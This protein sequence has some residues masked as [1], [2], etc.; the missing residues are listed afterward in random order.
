MKKILKENY[1]SK[2][3]LTE[4]IETSKNLNYHINNNL[5][6]S[7]SI[8][9]PYSDS[10]FSLISEVRNLY[11]ENKI[12]IPNKDKWLIES[13]LGKMV[14]LSNGEIVSLDCPYLI[15]EEEILTESKKK[16]DRCTRL[17]KQKYDV[18]PSAYASGA[19]VKCRQ[20]KIWKEEI[21]LDEATKTDYSKEK[22]QGLHGWFSRQ[23]GKGKTQGWVDCNTCRTD[24]NGKK[25]C[26]SCGR[27]E[28]E[29]RSK[30]PACRPTPSACGTKGKGEKWGK[31]TKMGVK[32]NVKISNI[33]KYYIN[34][35]ILLSENVFKIYSKNYFNLINEV[36]SLYEKNLIKLNE[37]DS[38]II[39]NNNEILSEA[40]YQG[41][42]V[43]L[44]Y[45]TRDTGGK[46]KY[47]VYVK[48]PKTGNIKKISFGDVH[49]G[50]T[51]KVSNPEA[52]KSFAARHNCKDKK[53]K[54][55][56][57]YWACN[58]PKFGH[59]WGGKTT[60]SYW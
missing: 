24:S 58:L 56:A 34:N 57:G 5:T 55:K 48:N 6:L 2:M 33:L 38:W 52:R 32:E 36:R 19:V 50:L 22:E 43:K 9:R 30:Y 39:E 13:D 60:N 1:D 35:N 47:K 41:K 21:E 18:W 16:D 42:N 23:G 17:A 14:V 54:T 11:E 25:T 3:V 29:E 53:D 59:L 7:E 27:S 12:Q 4:N 44:N 10:Y 45:P 20:G 46:K 28:G 15:T 40:E 31:K 37:E 8:F 26:K 51:A 49:G